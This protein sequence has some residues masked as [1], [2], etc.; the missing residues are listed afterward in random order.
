MRIDVVQ[1][2]VPAGGAIDPVRR[3][4]IET[5]GSPGTDIVIRLPKGAP[6]SITSAYEDAVA[7][8][9]VM[10]EAQAAEAEGA[11]AVI[12]NCTADTGAA[13]AREAMSIPVVAV[14]QAAFHL[15]AQLADSFSVLT[16]ASRI[17][18]RFFSMAHEWGMGRQL[19]SVRS[20]ETP[21]EDIND[22]SALARDLARE[23]TRCVQEDGAHLVILGCTDFELAAGSV[24]QSL[25]ADG[26]HVP[27]LCPF[28]IGVR[29]AESLVAMGLSHS[30]LSFPHPR[31]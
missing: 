9:G 30:A 28:A 5:A 11:D 23:A 4:A 25:A 14:S 8:P 3:K 27:L 26:L 19:R 31:I 22:H 21:L 1:A 20:V 10:A 13:G 29:Q 15:A 16:F 12:I 24:R 6:T 7:T 2:T 17:A 18:P